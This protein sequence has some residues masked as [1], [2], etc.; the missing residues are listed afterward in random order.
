MTTGIKDEIR[1]AGRRMT[2]TRQAVLTV[3]ESTRYPLSPVEIHAQLKKKNVAIDPVTVY[4]NLAALKELGLVTQLELHHEG[5]FRYE[6][7]Q[8]RD[9]HHHIRCNSCG[10]IADLLMCPLKKLTAVIEKETR[11][12]VGDHSLEW[13][14]WCPKCQ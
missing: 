12:I 6:I 5:R 4:R 2:R 3:L 7:K 13:S 11:F 8:G 9:H 1:A 10:R 14:G